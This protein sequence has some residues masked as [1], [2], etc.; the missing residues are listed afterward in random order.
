MPHEDLHGYTK[1]PYVWR[2]NFTSAKHHSENF[3]LVFEKP[4]NSAII[5]PITALGRNANNLLKPRNAISDLVKL[6]PYLA[7]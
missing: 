6:I 7:L 4:M 3:L 5:W 2:D 1:E